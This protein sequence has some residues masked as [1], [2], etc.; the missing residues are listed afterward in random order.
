MAPKKGWSNKTYSKNR[1]S[2][3]KRTSMKGGGLG[4]ISKLAPSLQLAGAQPPVTSIVSTSAPFSSIM[5]IFF[6]VILGLVIWILYLIQDSIR[7]GTKN[8][9][10]NVTNMTEGF[11]GLV[12]T[13]LLASPGT[14]HD[15]FED[16]YEP[17]LRND[18]MYFPKDSSDVRGV[19]LLNQPL[20]PATCNSGMC[21][22]PVATGTN[23]TCLDCPNA[24][25]WPV[26]MKTRGFAP[27]FGQI[28]ILTHERGA[29]SNADSLHDNMILPLFGR[30][31]MNGRDK[32][33]YYTMSNTGSVNTKLPV[34]VRGKNCIAEYGCDE[35]NNGDT[36]FV[37]GYNRSFK[38]TIYENSL[39]SYIPFL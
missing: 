10:P 14:K 19:P 16:P 24:K 26:N 22:V 31:T 23:T 15:P 3:L 34:L 37:Q 7:S 18:G 6:L 28:G 5:Y 29:D 1:G 38:A 17:P 32:Y 36:V 39:F 20:L 35:I 27:D 12:N 21:N 8:E 33:Q 4:S 25:G 11:N 2:S 30:R 13:Y 9:K